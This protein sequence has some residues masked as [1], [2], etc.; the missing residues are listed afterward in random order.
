MEKLWQDLRY[1]ARVLGRSPGFACIAIL[2]LALGIGANT[3]IFSVVNSVLLR[4]LAYRQPQQL[5]SIR[6]VVPQL[7][8]YYP[9]FPVNVPG[10]LTWQRECHSFEAIAI[11]GTTSMDFTGHGQPQ[12]IDGVKVSANFFDALG[13]RPQLG[14]GFLP[15]E[16]AFGRDQEV[17]LT[18]SFW[19]GEFHGDP[20]LVGKTITLNGAPFVVVGILPA[21]FH[22]PKALGALSTFGTH[23]DYFKPYGDKVSDIDLIGEFDYAAIARLKPGVTPEQALADLN[24]VQARIAKQAKENLDL[25]AT[26]TPLD[27]EVVGPARRGLFMLLA[28]VGAVLLIVCVNL[29]NLLLARVPA[30]MREAAI[31][32]ALGASRARLARQML[33]ESLL[34]ALGGGALGI[35]IA[36]AGVRWF[37]YSAPVAIPRLDEVRVDPRVLIFAFAVA[38]LT[39]IFFG[40][41]PAWRVAHAAPQEAIKA[42]AATTTETRPTRRLRESLIALEVGLSTL[43][44]ILGGLLTVSMARLLNVNKGFSAENAI[45]ADVNLPPSNYAAPASKTHFYDTVTDSLRALPGVRAAGWT[46]RLPLQSETSVS[47]I[48]TP[49]ANTPSQAPL[50]QYRIVSADYFAAIGIPLRSGRIF[51]P[52][53]QGRAV[54]VLSQNAAEKLWPGQ[55]P[56]GQICVVDWNGSH[57]EE[58]IGIVGDVHTTGLDE[59]PPLEVY[60]PEWFTSTSGASFV[61]RAAMDPAAMG[62]AIRSAIHQADPSVPITALR[63]L[64]V[65]VS[66]SVA[67]RRFQMFLAVCFALAALFLAAL[68]TYGVLSYSVERRRHEMGIR[69]ALGAQAGDLRWLVLRQGMLPVIA[70]LASGIAAALVFGRLVRSLLFSVSDADPL[71][72]VAVALVVLLAAALACYVPAARTTRLDPMT[73]L[74]YE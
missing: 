49:G 73:A 1:A 53:D 7:T 50:A 47:D 46:S 12:Q 11:A 61:I 5:Y 15:G 27:S 16:D 63:P 44:L 29:A 60:V 6:E 31:R 58:V 13:V 23:I 52:A 72:L 10:F 54:V 69:M 68:G 18:D 34:L 41:L 55:N 38:A 56:V 24:V 2:T 21:S 64:S 42:G 4:P 74:R 45:A 8:K 71:T 35:G 51:T 62:G 14:R 59:A 30:R 43:L 70:G 33:T 37:V 67:P 28:A 3:A 9:S 20:A 22:F 32:T 39:G 25:R 19:R 48:S 57:K 36:Y 65:L 40:V 17:V 66:D 26:M